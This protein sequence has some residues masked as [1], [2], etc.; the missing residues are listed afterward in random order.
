MFAYVLFCFCLVCSV[1]GTINTF[2][3]LIVWF[4]A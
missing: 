3:D 1:I 4:E 2:A